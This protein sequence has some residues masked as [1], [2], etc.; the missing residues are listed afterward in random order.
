[1]KKLLLFVLL[2][3]SCS[4]SNAQVDFKPGYLINNKNE[5][6]ICLIKDISR[7]S[8]PSK[9]VYKLND[10]SIHYVGVIDSVM[11]FQINDESKFVRYPLKIDRNGYDDNTASYTMKPIYENDT[12]F[13]KQLVDGKASLYSYCEG[14]MEIFFYSLNDTSI[15]Q[16]LYKVYKVPEQTN[17][18]RSLK[19]YTAQLQEDLNCE[20]IT[21]N[22]LKKLDYTNSDLITYF[23]KYNSYFKPEIEYV[24]TKTS[25]GKL[26]L[27][28]KTGINYASFKMNNGIDDRLDA[29]FDAKWG[30]NI[31][32]DLEYIFPYSNNKWALLISPRFQYYYDSQ[33]VRFDKAY[34]K[35]NLIDF[36]IGIR[37][38]FY[39][40]KNSKL[41]INGWGVYNL[42]INSRIDY[43]DS[44]KVDMV[45]KLNLNYGIG[46]NYNEKYSVELKYGSYKNITKGYIWYSKYE[47]LAIEFGY[48]IF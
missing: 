3:A 41:Y 28:F 14:S 13:L 37:H 12:L 24:N 19:Y 26:F 23:K 17:M 20:T 1:M 48:N 44:R 27:Y 22:D 10:E 29:E 47:F 32:L 35:Y 40:N 4:I 45:I 5:K 16:L 11:E 46:F 21:F 30:P 15:E 31:S 36:P 8:N 7:K 39:L 18:T 2:V 34:A 43:N 33:D 42:P 25:K 9:F 38:Y 6:V